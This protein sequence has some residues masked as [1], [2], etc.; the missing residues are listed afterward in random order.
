MH[1]QAGQVMGG[2]DENILPQRVDPHDHPADVFCISTLTV[3]ANRARPLHP[4]TN[5]TRNSA[6]SRF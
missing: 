2:M 3:S 4:A 6:N 1:I 5:G